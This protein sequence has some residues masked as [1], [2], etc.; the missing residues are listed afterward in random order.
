MSVF[1]GTDAAIDTIE[2]YKKYYVA[3]TAVKTLRWSVFRS[4]CIPRLTHMIS[5]T[6]G[7]IFVVG[8][9]S[10]AY[11]AAS[12][13]KVMNIV[14][15]L[16]DRTND[17]VLRE[18]R[19]SKGRVLLESHRCSKQACSSALRAQIGQP[20]Q[21]SFAGSSFCHSMF[22]SSLGSVQIKP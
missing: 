2:R 7:A 4:T 6:F 15:R 9:F 13:I 17:I 11:G 22:S 16:L 19:Y 20:E 12:L 21:A 18:S 1:N 3:P 10:T 5:G 14:K 8:M